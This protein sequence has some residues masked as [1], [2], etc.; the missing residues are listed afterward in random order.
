MPKNLFVDSVAFPFDSQRHWSTGDDQQ[1]K[2]KYMFLKSIVVDFAMYDIC[3]AENNKANNEHL[4]AKVNQ[5]KTKKK[6]R[7]FERVRNITK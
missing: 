7:H 1:S 2:N 6:R 3:T 5:M 4:H